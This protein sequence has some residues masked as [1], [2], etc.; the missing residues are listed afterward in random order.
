MNRIISNDCDRPRPVRKK[1]RVGQL[2]GRKL[3]GSVEEQRES[4]T[5]GVNRRA[6][7]EEKQ[8]ES[9]YMGY[10]TAERAKS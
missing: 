7:A 1:L 2:F 9:G 6:G 8:K 5:E 4:M 10:S 3:S